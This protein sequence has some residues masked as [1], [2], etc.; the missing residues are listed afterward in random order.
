MITKILIIN[1]YKFES[2]LRETVAGVGDEGCKVP[3]PSGIN[4]LPN[5]VQSLTVAAIFA[6]LFGGTAL[7]SGL[8]ESLSTSFPLLLSWKS[9]FPLLGPIFVLAG[10]SHFAIKEDFCNIMPATGAWGIW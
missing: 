9:T 8:F 1:R 2:R 3:S 10:Y 6:G 4:T 7:L 5:S